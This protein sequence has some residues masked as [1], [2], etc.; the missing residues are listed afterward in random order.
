MRYHPPKQDQIK[1]EDFDLYH[2]VVAVAYQ[3]HDQM[4]G[5]LL[6]KVGDDVTVILMS[7]HGFHPDHLRPKAIPSIPAGPAIEHRDFGILA[8][9]GPGI[10]RDELLH[11]ASVLDITPTL[12]SLF[13][14]PVGEDMDGKVLVRAFEDPPAVATIP[15]WDEVAGNDGRHPPH[16]RLDPVAAREALEQLVALG[17]IARPDPNNGKAVADTVDELRYNL[18]E[19][20][21]DADRHAEALEIFRELHQ[22]DPDEQRYAVHRF[23]SCQALGLVEEMRS[24]VA[25][26]DGRRRE[27][28]VQARARLDEFATLI[29]QRV[30]ERKP[31]AEA[32]EPEAVASELEQDIVEAIEAELSPSEAEPEAVVAGAGEGE[33]AV[34]EPKKPEPLLT[35]EEREEFAKWRNLSRF[36]PPVIDYLMAQVLA[37][38]GSH[39]QA[40][41]TLER[42]QEA[43]LARPGLLLQTADSISSSSAGTR[44]RRSLPGRSSSIPTTLMPI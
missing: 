27:L 18:G 15:S 36:Q 32:A 11:G 31:K 39:A 20:Y 38:E 33:P 8:I 13:G 4:L 30:A 2:N 43:D 40:L 9:K 6:E 17:Y 26:L 22:R 34:T 29:K 23:V 25:D 5:V 14:L 16:T 19:S 3:F 21:Q 41:E 42:V 7:D 10:K 35:A 44:P 28:F 1:Q 24:I 37:M 12:L